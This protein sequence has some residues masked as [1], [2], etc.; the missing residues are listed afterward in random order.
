VRIILICI[1]V[2]ITASLEYGCIKE[3]SLG[4]ISGTYVLSGRFNSLVINPIAS[5][6]TSYLISNDTILVC[7]SGVNTL[8]FECDNAQYNEG[9]PW[10]DMRYNPTANN[11]NGFAFVFYETISWSDSFTDTFSD[12]AWFDSKHKTVSANFVNSFVPCVFQT[13]L[14]GNKIR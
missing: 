8:Q 1:S 11:S 13:I 6:D 10:G 12:T 3:P 4:A 9:S 2:F 14:H 7:N 5:C